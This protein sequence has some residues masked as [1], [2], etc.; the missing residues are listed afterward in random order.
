M[1][2]AALGELITSGDASTRRLGSDGPIT[3]PNLS[4]YRD[5]D[6]LYTI[7]SDDMNAAEK[8][9]AA[10]NLVPAD[11]TLPIDVVTIR[12][13][14]FSGSQPKQSAQFLIDAGQ[15]LFDKRSPSDAGTFLDGD[16]SARL[17]SEQKMTYTGLMPRNSIKMIQ[18]EQMKR[19]LARGLARLCNRDFYFLFSELSEDACHDVISKLTDGRLVIDL[20]RQGKRDKRL[21][22]WK[23]YA[24]RDVWLEPEGGNPK[25]V[26]VTRGLRKVSDVLEIWETVMRLDGYIE[27][28]RDLDLNAAIRL[29]DDIRK[30]TNVDLHVRAYLERGI[31]PYD[32]FAGT[33]FTASYDDE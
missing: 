32:M 33:F 3:S 2:A 8:L 25:D 9:H 10:G 16:V 17:E 13:T 7:V 28:R 27:E 18:R 15:V 22:E 12:T 29:L 23:T 20:P 24:M 5:F 1:V 19:I 30:R 21:K 11:A 26:A 14:M 4:L 31:S 6:P